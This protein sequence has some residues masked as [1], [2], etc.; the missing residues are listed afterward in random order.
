MSRKMQKSDP[1]APLTP[2]EFNVVCHLVTRAAMNGQSVELF[3]L[4]FRENPGLSDLVKDDVAKG[5]TGSMHA[6][7]SMHDGSKRQRDVADPFDFPEGDSPCSSKWGEVTSQ[8]PDK[9]VGKLTISKVLPGVKLQ[10]N[11]KIPLGNEV[12][13]IDDWSTT[14][15][16]M[17]KYE[18][19][20]WRYSN[21]VEAA[22]N[23]KEVQKYMTWIVKTYGKDI[24]EPCENQAT[25][26]ARFLLRINWL[27]F[28]GGAGGY[29]RER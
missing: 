26:L 15:L 3:H 13:D 2:D 8:H 1:S 23:D 16:T 4:L 17:K 28:H 29:R 21:L 5:A 22:K 6:N 7:G 14:K 19:K 9:H 18:S 25:D 20:G 12:T 27:E 10:E 11:V 24:S